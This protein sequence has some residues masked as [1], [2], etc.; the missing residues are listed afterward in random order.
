MNVAVFSTKAFDRIF[1]EKHN[2]SYGHN[3]VFFEER[4]TE[5][6][7]ALAAG[8]SAVCVFVNDQLNG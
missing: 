1:L 5:Q 8:F 7:S 4:L 2:G 6:S 3:I